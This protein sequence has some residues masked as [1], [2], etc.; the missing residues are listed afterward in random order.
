[1]VDK[2]TIDLGVILKA[3]SK[4]RFS[5]D[6]FN[7]RLRLQ[8]FVYLLQSF[9]VFLGYHY[10]WYV[11]GPYCST[12]ATCGFALRD[13]YGVIPEGTPVRFADPEIQSRFERFRR[14]ISKREMDDDFLEIAASIHLLVRLGRE[15]R[16]RIIEHV[17]KKQ[18]RFTTDQVKNVWRELEKWNLLTQ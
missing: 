7:D 3:F 4:F 16:E 2:Q 12:L 9:D 18:K 14:F 11:H 17:A 8:K 1:M 6:G 10:S 5:M 13:I 15:S